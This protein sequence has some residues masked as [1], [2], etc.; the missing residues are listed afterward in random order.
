MG[1]THKKEGDSISRAEDSLRFLILNKTNFAI[2]QVNSV[3]Y[4]PDSLPYGIN[5][6]K[7]LLTVTVNTTYGANKVEMV[8]PDSTY[9]WNTTDSVDFSKMPVKMRVYAPANNVKEYDIKLLIH[10]I[11]PDVFVWNNMG[12]LPQST[13]KQKV[14]IKGDDFYLYTVE[15][16][17]VKLFK[18]NKNSLSWTVENPSILPAS[19]IV[20]S[21]TYFNGKFM[22]ISSEGNSYTSDNG[23]DWT[24]QSNGKNVLA[25]YGVIPGKAESDDVLL[26]LMEKSGTYVLG[27]T[28]DMISID[29]PNTVGLGSEDLI[30]VYEFASATNYDRSSNYKFLILTGGITR[31]SGIELNSTVI[32]EKTSGGISV[33]RSTKNYLF[34]GKGLSTFFYSENYL[35]TIANNQLYLSNSWGERWQKAPAKQLLDSGI[36]ERQEQSVVV[37]NGNIWL[38]GGK[39]S[40]TGVYL[41]DVWKGRLNGFK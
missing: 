2:N 21:I 36:S 24:Q 25:V 16:G 9:E 37:E 6:D 32:I 33:T 13:G 4:N 23:T 27:T 39:D 35:Y 11:D 18:S 22:A 15:S 41:N 5:L 30:P 3:I 31:N 34:K 28:N 12:V 40:T 26:L 8:L 19:V 7:V 38:F 14:L 17:I 10:K 20:N 1:A 29:E